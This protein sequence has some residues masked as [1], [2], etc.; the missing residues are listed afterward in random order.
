MYVNYYTF[1]HRGALLN[2][3]AIKSFNI[4]MED[5]IKHKY[6]MYMDF[7][8]DLLPSFEKNLPQVRKHIGID[9]EHWQ[10]DSIKKDYYRYRLRTGRPLLYKNNYDRIVV[11]EKDHDPA[12]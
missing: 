1:Y 6:R 10:D 12:F 4:F 3:T 2:E 5:E 9:L 7:Y 11:A 8:I